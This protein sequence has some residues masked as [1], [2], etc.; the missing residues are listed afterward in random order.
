MN[1]TRQGLIR[2]PPTASKEEQA[3]FYWDSCYGKRSAKKPVVQCELPPR[4]W[5][6]NRVGPVKSCMSA[7]KTTWSEIAAS[8]SKRRTRVVM[9]HGKMNA[10]CSPIEKVSV[11]IT[12]PILFTPRKTN[13]DSGRRSVNFGCAAADEFDSSQPIFQWTNKLV[14]LTKKVMN[15]IEKPHGMQPN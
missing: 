10:T 8:A 14:I 6:V 13:E 7:K 5:S 2:L 9:E 1:S 12:I 15:C 3:R 4:N 11:A